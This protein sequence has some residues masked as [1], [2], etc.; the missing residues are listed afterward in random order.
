MENLPFEVLCVVFDALARPALEPKGRTPQK[1]PSVFGSAGTDTVAAYARATLGK[2]VETDLRRAKEYLGPRDIRDLRPTFDA[3]RS[4]A[5]LPLVRLAATSAA[6]NAAVARW[7]AGALE[8]AGVP[9][10]VSRY[11]GSFVA[12][13][14]AT[15]AARKGLWERPEETRGHVAVVVLEHLCATD[16]G[17]S[18]ACAETAST[19]LA[20]PPAGARAS[21]VP[22]K[23][24]ACDLGG[25]SLPQARVVKRF[26]GRGGGMPATF[27]LRILRRG[28][29]WWAA[30]V[31]G[32]D[33]LAER[34]AERLADWTAADSAVGVA[35][36]LLRRCLTQELA[37]RCARASPEWVEA[38]R[39]GLGGRTL[40]EVLGRMAREFSCG[41]DVQIDLRTSEMNGLWRL[42]V[43]ATDPPAAFPAVRLASV[44]LCAV[45]GGGG[46][47]PTRN[48]TVASS[49]KTDAEPDAR[50]LHAAS[51]L[52]AMLLPRCSGAW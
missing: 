30:G 19:W 41:E 29:S 20:P 44:T 24:W 46:G 33:E 50:A 5:A 9:G 34:L 38:S 8:R 13:T 43:G 23:E 42:P 27:G 2:R 26:P 22:W 4:R 6:M 35:C 7:A 15:V 51:R 1:T 48:R 39:P 11:A 28:S 10:Q 21:P 37:R 18:L 25:L 47:G 32:A 16:E 45:S 14:Q 17:A 36:M 40:A 31:A 3:A 12:A 49:P 52:G